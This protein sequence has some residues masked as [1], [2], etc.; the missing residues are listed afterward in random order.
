MGVPAFY[1]WLSQK[2]EKAVVY[3]KEEQPRVV[4]GTRIPVDLLQ[5]NPNEYEFDN[6]YL[7]FNGIIHPCA[8]PE[9]RPAP[10]TEEEMMVNIF[11]T[12]DRLFSI[13]RPRKMVYIAVDGVA[14]RAKM[15]QQRSRRFRTAAEAK[16]IAAD[17][18]RLREKFEK[19]GKPLPP[20]KDKKAW[21]SNA[22]TPGTHFMAKAE[23]WMEWYI[24]Q[25][26][27]TDSAWAN[28][29]VLLSSS[30]VPGEGEHKIMEFV[31]RQRAAP[32]YDPNTRH[33]ICGLDADLI[34]LALA[35]HEPFFA[36]LREEVI[37]GRKDQERKKRER[38]KAMEAAALQ[39]E[40]EAAMIAG[41]KGSSGEIS[42]KPDPSLKPYQFLHV[43]ILR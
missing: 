12:V 9:D 30:S 32:G 27:S 4:D 22:I 7:D 31:R 5:P 14:P 33:V 1:R 28:V 19:L 36:I 18:K 6:L 26:L 16:E 20:S 40:V 41:A 25:R 39:H 37:F 3:A 29:S 34:M 23:L 35:T 2:F 24:L 15:N 38:E 42:Y 17:K 43:H 8:H 21:D 11:R 10:A 13:V